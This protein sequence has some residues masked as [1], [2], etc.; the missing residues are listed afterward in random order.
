M[1]KPA[2]VLSRRL[3]LLALIA[4]V[5]LSAS[6]NC[7]F[8]KPS[9]PS[10]DLDLTLPIISKVYTMTKLAEDD[11][12]FAIDSTGLLGFRFE[13]EL[14]QYTVGDQLTMDD[15]RE[16]V[17][18]PIGNFSVDSPGSES[19]GLELREIF[20]EAED[21][22]GETVEVPAFDFVSRKKRLD[23]YDSFAF[24]VIDT[25]HITL[26]VENNLVIP[27]GPPVG[28]QLWDTGTDTLIAEV[29]RDVQIPPNE[30]SF[31]QISLAGRTIP[32]QVSVVVIGDSPGSEGEPV[33]VD[34]FSQ[35]NV[36]SEI[37]DLLVDEALAEVPEQRFT[38]EESV[39]ITDSVVVEEATITR[40]ALQLS[41]GD[42]FPLD[43]WIR[44]ELPD[45]VA[46]NGTPIVDSVLVSANTGTDINI[47][48]AGHRLMPQ[49]ADFGQQAVR[50]NWTIRTIDSGTNMVLVRSSDVV[51]A[52]VGLVDFTFASIKG[53]LADQSVALEES[54]FEFDVPADL[55][56]LFFERATLR[57]FID[58]TINFPARA[59]LDIQGQNDAGAVSDLR[60]DAAIKPAQQA[61]VPVTSVI[62]LNQD[63]SNIKDF[64]SILPSL[65]RVAGQVELGDPT[66]TGEVSSE[67]FV[68]GRMEI[69]AP[70][71]LRL[72]AQTIDSEAS[73]LE[74]DEDTRRD[75]DENL[76]SGQFFA[77]VNNH[78]P[79]GASVQFLFGEDETTLFE[80]PILEIGPLRV[81]AG[82]FGS[83]G[84]V[85]NAKLSEIN[86]ELT[87]E[88]MRTFTR[89]PLFAALRISLD[90]S[91]SQ[92]IQVRGSDYL[93][94][95]SYGRVKLKV[96]QD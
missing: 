82:E 40:G 59:R 60:V 55:D 50:M 58:N 17:E 4:A 80:A 51:T 78:L 28:L 53:K 93:Q 21:L 67:D 39:T 95:K 62:K 89:S 49:P 31:F 30:V 1:R 8:D 2:S 71:A 68:S 37:S 20:P 22:H 75:I 48:L 15:V 32:N 65:I 43:A 14:D 44:Y 19:V 94:I 72:P 45:F 3:G 76:A 23:P 74:F 56:S 33:E 26:R 10:W 91:G 73:E 25:G 41:L 96:N 16:S 52:E 83:D 27:L 90:G 9:A 64:I 84:L 79:L 29:S 13:T 81:A 34:A 46:P 47:D 61:G 69:E 12:S 6:T 87:E 77:E 70:V 54:E 5:T 38:S 11:S 86:V 57:L 66:W 85:A 88:Q 42:A 7:S 92:V 35:F 24:V 63:N 36:V 18:E